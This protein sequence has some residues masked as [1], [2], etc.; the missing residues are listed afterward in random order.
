MAPDEL[1]YEVD[2]QYRYVT[3]TRP[4]AICMRETMFE[5]LIAYDPE[6]GRIRE[7][8]GFRPNHPGTTANWFDSVKFCRWLGTQLGLPE[9]DQAYSDP[10]SPGLKDIQ[11][12]PTVTWAPVRW[13]LKLDRH[14]FRLPTEAEWEIAA[15]SGT[16]T[17][18]AFGSDVTHV[19]RYGWC[20]RRSIGGPQ[21]TRGLRPN[22]RGLHDMHGNAS[23]WTADFYMAPPTGRER[24]FVDSLASISGLD[25][26]AL[27][28][29]K[30]D[31]LETEGQ[32]MVTRGGSIA[33]AGEICTSAYRSSVRPQDGG[34]E[35]GFRI[36]FTLP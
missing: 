7:Q 28:S 16:R 2:S 18:F 33:Y 11:R 35:L 17:P 26:I 24:V 29:R 4:F 5:D 20:R 32:Q 21:L 9:T 8:Y 3:L 34:T 25:K 15:R 12:H 1:S 10:K 36:A 14:G 22:L 23:E 30:V 6:Y 13:P 27:Q 19:S 31:P